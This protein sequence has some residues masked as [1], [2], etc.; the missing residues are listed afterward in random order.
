MTQNIKKSIESVFLF[1]FL[2]ILLYSLLLIN[3]KDKEKQ[4]LKPDTVE[5]TISEIAEGS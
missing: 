4:V 5:K 3:R 1:E 2:Y